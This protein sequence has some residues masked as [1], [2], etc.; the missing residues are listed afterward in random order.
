[1]ILRPA[2]H[3]LN[4]IPKSAEE[5]PVNGSQRLFSCGLGMLGIFA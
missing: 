5:T 1:M 3:I 4:V 2:L